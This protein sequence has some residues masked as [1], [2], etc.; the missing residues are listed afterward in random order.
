VGIL[1]VLLTTCPN[2]A[3]NAG[4]IDLNREWASCIYFLKEQG[5]EKDFKSAV[6]QHENALVEKEG[7]E[8]Q[9]IDI[10][11]HQEYKY[12]NDRHRVIVAKIISD[13]FLYFMKQLKSNRKIS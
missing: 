5:L 12:E 7:E 9:E 13:F 4:G 1:R 8:E 6:F 10:S 11:V 2:A 3:K